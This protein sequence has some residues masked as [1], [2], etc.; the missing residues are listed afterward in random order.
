MSDSHL[1]TNDLLG[2]QLTV[3][4]RAYNGAPKTPWQAAWTGKVRGVEIKPNG[5]ELRVLLEL[6]ESAANDADAVIGDLVV[7]ESGYDGRFGGNAYNVFSLTRHPALIQT[8]RTDR[9]I[10]AR[11]EKGDWRRAGGDALCERCGYTYLQHPEV[12]G[13]ALNILCNG[14]LVKL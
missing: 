9:P 11:V 14:D 8:H 13:F 6:T 3:W 1:L 12:R 4:T 7:V 2:K 5:V 10:L